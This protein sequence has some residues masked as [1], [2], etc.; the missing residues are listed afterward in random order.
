[1]PICNPVVLV[2][3]APSGSASAEPDLQL[4]GP[5]AM[6]APG[7]LG[8]LPIT[9]LRNICLSPGLFLFVLPVLL[10]L[11]SLFGSALVG[12]EPEPGFAAAAAPYVEDA[13]A[14]AVGLVCARIGLVA[15]LEERNYALARGIRRACEREPG[16]EGGAAPRAADDEEG[17]VVA[18]LGMAHLNGV[19]EL[20]AGEE[21]PVPRPRAGAR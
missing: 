7:L 16:E 12:L 14:L 20:L 21:D 1:M 9:I 11:D 19:R 5:K 2:R 10:S 13:W 15:L 6:L 3:L 17:A 8:G 18:V 4:V